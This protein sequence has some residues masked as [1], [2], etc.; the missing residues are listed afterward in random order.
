MKLWMLP[1]LSFELLED[2]DSLEI[3]RRPGKRKCRN[4]APLRYLKLPDAATDEEIHAAKIRMLCGERTDGWTYVRA[5]T[6]FRETKL[7]RFSSKTTTKT[8]AAWHLE[9]H[10]Q[11]E[12]AGPVDPAELQKVLF[13]RQLA[14]LAANAEQYKKERAEFRDTALEQSERA[15]KFHALYQ[16]LAEEKARYLAKKALARG[17][18]VPPPED[19]PTT[20]T[21][22]E[23]FN[24]VMKRKLSAQKLL[25]DLCALC[26][27]EGVMNHGHER[28]RTHR[29]TE[30]LTS[31]T[32]VAML[33]RW[34]KENT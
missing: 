11:G 15:K 21:P 10:G 8:K 34:H 17:A 19:Q 20:S 6:V 33:N 7:G 1:D 23:A 31:D 26:I 24:R 5:N 30:L 3:K 9:P 2:A 29:L 22:A 32:A 18:P 27:N 13:F 25:L 12:T 4:G 28:T 16:Q 14:L